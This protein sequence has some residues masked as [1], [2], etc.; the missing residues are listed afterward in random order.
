MIYR[1]LFLFTI[2]SLTACVNVKIQHNDE[3]DFTV[4]VLGN[5]VEITG[6]VGK[7]KDVSIPPKI[8]GLPVT[9]IGEYAFNGK[10]LDSVIIPKSVTRI[11]TYAFMGNQ[12]TKVTI[13]KSVTHIEWGA[14][15]HN[16]LTSVTIPDSV[17][18]IE[19][20]AF[21]FNNLTKVNIPEK[22]STIESGVFSFNCL[23]NIMIP[24]NIL[25]I[26]SGAFENN[27]LIEVNISKNVTSIGDY[28]FT[29]NNDLAKITIGDNV[30][31]GRDAFSGRFAY[32]PDFDGTY[33]YDYNKRG[34]TYFLINGQWV[35]EDKTIPVKVYSSIRD[36]YR[37]G[38]SSDIA[39]LL[40]MPDLTAVSLSENDKL[41]DITS[42]S[43]LLKLESLNIYECPSIENIESLS[44]LINLKNL[45]IYG[46]PKIKSI[47]PLSSLTSLEYLFIEHNKNYDYTALVPLRRLEKLFLYNLYGKEDE[48]IDLSPIG[49]LH[50]LKEL[51]ILGKNININALNQLINLEKLR[52]D[53]ITQIDNLKVSWGISNGD[54]SWVSD[55]RNLTYLEISG[56]IINDLSPLANLPNLT[57]V[58][59]VYNRLKD[60]S[61]LLRSNS[62]KY[63]RVWKHEVEVGIS[64]EL[65]SRFAQKN[66]TL[67]TFYDD[68]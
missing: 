10:E 62:I 4:E 56:G 57:E 1:F 66:I 18:S 45:D 61:P 48:I 34:G 49:Q 40:D 23:T 14:F 53:N 7:N 50:S 27:E 36:R 22:I 16:Q 13:P 38:S 11:R 68:R 24:E 42:L 15:S 2:L 54:I 5:S 51:E 19:S 3:N 37:F 12:I 9:V 44:P 31:L 67:D 20:D 65:A 52:V 43:K 46:C 63:I 35:L 60:I 26:G 59:L 29:E 25:S 39:F 30:E 21:I 58:H 6:Y 17:I 41:T 47:K 64:V 8:K 33:N 28:A 32:K 55:M